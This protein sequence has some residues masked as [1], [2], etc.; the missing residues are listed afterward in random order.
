MPGL[1]ALIQLEG[2]RCLVVGGGMVAV[3]RAGALIEAG[4]SVRVV[5]PRI[6]DAFAD[7]N[8]AVE[9][10]GFEPADL[11]GVFLV[12]VA[13]DDAEVNE[14]VAQAARA[15]S[16]LLNRAD[17]PAAGDVTIPAHRRTGPITLAVDTGGVSASAAAKIRDA[18]AR[19]IDPV[20]PALLEAAS[21]VRKEIQE[22]FPDEHSRRTR[23][24]RALT[25][26]RSM[27]I[28]EHRGLDALHEHWRRMIERANSDG[29][30]PRDPDA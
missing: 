28:L 24:L 13:T 2:R 5:A 18:L 11:D 30:E 7:M 21:P 15:R 16:V 14:A 1:P 10:R 17:R 20:W 26:P 9:R 27:T 12:V 25:D 23:L 3:R 8:V 29:A 22:R 6:E 4:G 19:S